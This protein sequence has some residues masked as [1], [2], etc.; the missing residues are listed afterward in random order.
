MSLLVAEPR[1]FFSQFS[2]AYGADYVSADGRLVIDEPEIRKGLV[3][4]VD[5]YVEIYRKGCTPP[6]SVAWGYTDNNKA[7]NSQSVVM[8]RTR[9]S[10]SPTS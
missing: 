6:G 7:F 9:R 5:R 2:S 3:T 10:R 1:F 8:T 4:A